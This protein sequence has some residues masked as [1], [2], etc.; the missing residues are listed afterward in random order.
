[1][2]LNGYTFILVSSIVIARLPPATDGN[3]FRYLQPDMRCY[4]FKLDIFVRLPAVG[5]VVT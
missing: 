3:D 2:I 1:M 4:S 5:V